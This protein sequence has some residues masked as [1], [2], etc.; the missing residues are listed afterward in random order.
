MLVQVPGNMG[1][2][3]IMMLHL[4]QLH[5]AWL[6]H[7]SHAGMAD[8]LADEDMDMLQDVCQNYHELVVLAHS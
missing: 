8:A 6:H 2:I 4:Y 7:S 1:F 3:S 5:A